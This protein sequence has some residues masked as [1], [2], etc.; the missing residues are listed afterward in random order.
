[1]SE[2]KKAISERKQEEKLERVRRIMNA[3]RK[4]FL[5]KG[6]LNTKIR[7]IALEAQLSTGLI[8]FYFK[9]KDEIYGE[10]CKEI[11]NSLLRTFKK[12]LAEEDGAYD[13]LTAL[14]TAYMKFFT[15]SGNHF[16]II[17]FKDM[18]YKKVGLSKPL[19]RELDAL[20]LALLSLVNEEVKVIMAEKKMPDTNSWELTF[21]LWGAVEGAFFIQKRGYFDPQDVSLDRVVAIQLDLFKR[22]LGLA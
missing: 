14:T 22:G 4:V 1:M 9:N 20:S 2:L 12:V 15:E 6:Y 13:R 11:F 18:G 19:K 21:A 8:Y 16:D 17:S 7:D 5:E 3:S 10:L